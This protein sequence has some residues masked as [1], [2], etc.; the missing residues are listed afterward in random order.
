MLPMKI[1]F[2]VDTVAG[3]LNSKKLMVPGGGIEPPHP[4]GYQILNLARLPVPPSRHGLGGE[5]V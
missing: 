3:C 4:F 2:S 1:E 5:A